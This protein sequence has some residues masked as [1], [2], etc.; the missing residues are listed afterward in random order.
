MRYS[1]PSQ[2]YGQYIPQA[3]SVRILPSLL[4]PTFSHFARSFATRAHG[5]VRFTGRESW[6]GLLST[7][8]HDATQLPFRL[9][10]VDN[11]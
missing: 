4:S 10:I 6:I 8:N 7:V 1:V 5:R 2:S 3:A 9:F 11:F